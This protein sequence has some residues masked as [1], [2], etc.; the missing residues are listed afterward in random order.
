MSHY[1]KANAPS[2]LSWRRTYSKFRLGLL[3][4]SLL[5]QLL[6]QLR[7]GVAVAEVP[8]GCRVGLAGAAFCF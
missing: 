3:R 7:A 1:K 5:S 2:W 8:L 6:S 4:G